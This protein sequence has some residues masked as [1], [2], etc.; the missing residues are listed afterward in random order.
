M[1]IVIKFKINWIIWIVGIISLILTLSNIIRF[2]TNKKN[3]DPSSSSS[4]HRYE[5]FLL[6]LNSRS[7]I[8]ATTMARTTTSKKA[9][10][11]TSSSSKQTSQPHNVVIVTKVLSSEYTEYQRMIC[12]VQAAYNDKH[13]YDYVIF[14]TISW[15]ES[16]IVEAQ[17]LVQPASLK[18]VLES[19]Q[20]STLQH[21]LEAL[22]LEERIYL[23][24]RCGVDDG[25]YTRLTWFSHCHEPNSTNVASL[26]YSWQAEFRAYHIWN[27]QALARYKYMIWFDGDAHLTVPL[28]FDPIQ[29][30]IE[31]NLTLLGYFPQGRIK[32][33]MPQGPEFVS[34]LRNYDV[35]GG[36]VSKF[37]CGIT[38]NTDTG[39]LVP[40]ICHNLAKDR[41]KFVFQQIGGF[42]HVTN[43]DVYRQ[44]VHQSFLKKFISPHPFSRIWDDQIATT[45]VA[46]YDSYISGSTTPRM[47][48]YRSMG[49]NLRLVHHGAYDGNGGFDKAPRS[50]QALM[51]VV[52][53]EQFPNG[54]SMC[55]N[56]S[57]P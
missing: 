28:Q 7:T 21:R 17:N 47:Y 37:L 49:Y 44:P 29:V 57:G 2:H 32:A 23:A 48:D 31:K 11:P 36:D 27:H 20:Y 1:T 24:K 30:M 16:K 18:V 50:K 41:N 13:N 42:H 38:K 53:Q 14:T 8:N 4:S 40:K 3:N 22:S 56:T 39:A 43:L 6:P 26:G 10:T 12:L 19:P 34:K 51:E 33:S 52:I 46:A 55:H 15:P 35:G 25:D 9:S 54:Y 5:D 45:V